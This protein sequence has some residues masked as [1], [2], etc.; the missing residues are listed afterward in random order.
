[1]HSIVVDHGIT[2]ESILELALRSHD[3]DLVEGFLDETNE[4]C[5]GERASAKL[6]SS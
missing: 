4:Q 1:L 3:V 6:A 2:L 5:G